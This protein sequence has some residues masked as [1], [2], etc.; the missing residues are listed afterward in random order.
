M[1]REPGITTLAHPFVHPASLT[2][3]GQS[4]M[5]CRI[6]SM[7][8]L[9]TYYIRVAC[10]QAII[11]VGQGRARR[12]LAANSWGPM[13]DRRIHRLVVGGRWKN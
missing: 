8:K 7:A 13:K 3:Q 5:L 10:W 2:K 6:H 11:Q 4:K 12:P 9:P 1:G